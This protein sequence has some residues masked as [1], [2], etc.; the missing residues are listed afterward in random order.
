MK[1]RLVHLPR[2]LECPKCGNELCVERV[3]VDVVKVFHVYAG[4]P[5]SG[6]RALL[7]IR[8]EEVDAEDEYI[9]DAG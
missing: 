8:I 4:C 5:D 1:V 9:P 3:L 6:R 2:N 7:K